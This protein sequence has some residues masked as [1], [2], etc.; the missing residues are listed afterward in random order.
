MSDVTTDTT[1]DTTAAA[2]QQI[3]TVREALKITGDLRVGNINL[4]P[5]IG[6]AVFSMEEGEKTDDGFFPMRNIGQLSVTG[7][8]YP[9]LMKLT[10]E[11][12]VPIIKTLLNFLY[13]EF[14]SSL[15]NPIQVQQQA[16]AQ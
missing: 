7:E 6:Q 11:A 13:G 15:D 16:P 8:T 2:A 14:M 3:P 5:H 4:A 12:G 1:A 10:A 9:K